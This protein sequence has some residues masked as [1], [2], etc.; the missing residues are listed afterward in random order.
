MTLEIDMKMI[1]NKY[2]KTLSTIYEAI[3]ETYSI[4]VILSLDELL[5]NFKNN[6]NMSNNIPYDP[7]KSKQFLLKN[8]AFTGSHDTS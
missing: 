5:E 8:F 7:K 4:E 2:N 1:N 6:L 3:Y